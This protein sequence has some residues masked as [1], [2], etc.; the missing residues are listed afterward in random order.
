[1]VEG[2]SNCNLDFNFYEHYLYV[3]QNRVKFPSGATRSKKI[4]ESIHSDVFCHV[5]IPSLG[6]CLYYVRF[7]DYFSRNT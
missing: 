3:K 5:P 1:M 7:I 6:G 4:L 2:M